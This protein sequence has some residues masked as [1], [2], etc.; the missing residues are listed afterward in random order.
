MKTPPLADLLLPIPTELAA[1]DGPAP[2]VAVI[3]DLD[4]LSHAGPGGVRVDNATLATLTRVIEGS[5]KACGALRY[6][7]AGC[8]TD[9]AFV[10]RLA[11]V[12]AP[13]NT[14]QVAARRDGADACVIAELR[15]LARTRRM[16]LVILVAG[17]HAYAAPVADLRAA[18]IAVWVLYRAGS[19]S[20]RLY[21][22]ASSATPLPMGLGLRPQP[23]ERANRSPTVRHAGR[24]NSFR[25]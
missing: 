23:Q 24:P 3:Y 20:W 12:S 15:H 18:G 14:W 9:T 16:R 4:Y 10:H 8:S 7:R 6:V 22:V 25:G 21:Q 19:L 1:A 2:D 11:L 13:N 5:A 17:D